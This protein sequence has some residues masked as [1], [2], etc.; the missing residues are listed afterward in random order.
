MAFRALRTVRAAGQAAI[1]LGLGNAAVSAYWMLGGTA[2]LDTVGG[3]I[4]RWGRERGSLVLL[5]LAGVV[6]IKTAVAIVPLVDVGEHW[7]RRV[8]WIERLASWALVVYGGLLTAVGLL[9]QS[10]VIEASNDADTKAL[11]WH[12]YFWDPW[13]LL[14]GA[15]LMVH[16]RQARHVESNVTT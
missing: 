3:D 11:A 6:L 8:Q 12:T 5:A 16:L 13:F 4:E 1:F 7:K 9:L 2:M 10:D 15:A 14:W